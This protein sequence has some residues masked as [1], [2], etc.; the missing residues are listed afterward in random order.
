M[1]NLESIAGG[2]IWSAVALTLM[3]VAFEPVSLEQA[4]AATAVYAAAPEAGA[5]A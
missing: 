3:L 1:T 5:A 4:P 2:M